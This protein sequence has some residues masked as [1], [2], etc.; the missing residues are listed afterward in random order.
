MTSPMRSRRLERCTGCGLAVALCMCADM[1]K[2]ATA[3]RVVVIMH[4]NELPKSSNTGRLVLAVLGTASLRVRGLRGPARVEPPPEGRRLLLF[5]TRG[6][7]ELRAD[8]AGSILLVPDGSWGQAKRVASRDEWAIGAEPVRLPQVPPS[9]YGLRRNARPGTLCTF[10]AVVE[11]LAVVEGAEI[12]D[13]LLPVLST[14]LERM[15]FMR[16]SGTL[17]KTGTA[18]AEL[19]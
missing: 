12:R 14:F 7:R 13:A 1:P 10:E 2:L 4:R 8:D 17:L 11:A 16:E 18:R 6:A 9:R 15:R 5:P 19:R 3:T